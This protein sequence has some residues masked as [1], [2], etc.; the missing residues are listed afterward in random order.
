MK[1]DPVAQLPLGAYQAA[2]KKNPPREP[3]RSAAEVARMFGYASPSGLH[4]AVSEGRF[5]QPDFT[6]PNPALINNGSPRLFWKLSTVEKEKKRREAMKTL[7][8][9]LSLC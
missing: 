2:T 8:E 1:R 5:P 3:C 6:P 7:P 4:R 9:R